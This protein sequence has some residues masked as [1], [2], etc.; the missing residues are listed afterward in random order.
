LKKE[1]LNHSY[2]ETKGQEM[3]HPWVATLIAAEVMV[4]GCAMLKRLP[5]PD[6]CGV[7]A[8]S[9]AIPNARF[10]GEASPPDAPVEPG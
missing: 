8:D 2:R 3:K 7:L 1:G 4:S 9:S 5:P 10:R 6:T